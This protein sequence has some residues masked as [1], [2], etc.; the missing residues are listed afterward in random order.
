MG[1]L[2]E[3][4]LTELFQKDHSPTTIIF[5]RLQAGKTLKEL[6]REEFRRRV[7]HHVRT[8]WSQRTFLVRL[9]A[10]GLGLG[11]LVAFLI[12]TRYT[13]ITRLMA[14]DTFLERPTILNFR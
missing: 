13:S 14:L 9:S 12:P 5:Q 2:P 4:K 1:C 10:L 7:G 3:R 8:V 6:E 11:L